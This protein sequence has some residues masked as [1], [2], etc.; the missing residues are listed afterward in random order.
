[1][2]HTSFREE[3]FTLAI[4]VFSV[5]ITLVSFAIP[6]FFLWR[7]YKGYSANNAILTSGVRAPAKVL[8]ISTT[9]VTVNQSPQVRMRVEVQ[10]TDGRAPFMAQ[11]DAFVS[12]VAIPRVQP[13]CVVTVRYDPVDPS[14]VAMEAAQPPVS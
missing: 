6:G 2:T 8:E 7:L 9:G 4:V 3:A 10:P 12:I 1:M 14:R 5:L 13:G 11:L